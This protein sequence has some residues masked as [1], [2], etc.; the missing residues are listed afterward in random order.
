MNS[1]QVDVTES[2]K[3]VNLPKPDPANITVLTTNLPNKPILPWT[4]FDSPWLEDE[5]KHEEEG[6][7][8]LTSPAEE[9][10]TQA[11][12][13]PPQEEATQ[14][15]LCFPEIGVSEHQLPQPQV[16]PLTN[17]II[18]PQDSTNTSQHEELSQSQISPS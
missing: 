18:H 2:G 1:K 7:E 16:S 6:N 11:E 13:P 12:T 4:H 5:E 14:L 8:Q 15:E 3:S 17:A 10:A 9:E